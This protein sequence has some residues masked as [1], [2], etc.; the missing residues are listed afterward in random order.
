MTP[1]NWSGNFY[2]AKSFPNFDSSETGFY[3]VIYNNE[4]LMY[5][6]DFTLASEFTTMYVRRKKEEKGSS[7]QERFSVH[8][9]VV[10]DREF[11]TRRHG[12]AETRLDE[13]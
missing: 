9:H 11:S 3:S 13:I 2:V 4:R 1:I 7:Q 8:V 10:N 6:E 12:G 5:T